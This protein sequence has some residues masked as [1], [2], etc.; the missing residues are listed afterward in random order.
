MSEG[1]PQLLM[2]TGPDFLVRDIREILDR[3][4]ASLPQ[5]VDAAWVSAT[6]KIPFKVLV[7]RETLIWRVLELGRSALQGFETNKI[8]SAII[9]TRA[10]LETSAALW[11]LGAKLDGVI[12]AETLGDI[13]DKVMRL[14]FGSRVYPELGDAI[15]V[16]TFID[17]MDKE[18][19]GL[20]RSYD[21][22]SEY[23]HPNWA[24]AGLL[25]S[26]EDPHNL[27]TEFGTNIRCDESSKEVGV[28]S[29][30]GALLAFEVCYNRLADIL[31]V[32]IELCEKGLKAAQTNN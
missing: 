21:R 10:A 13:D 11:Y 15:N 29:L 31:R 3:I 24:G 27:S 8:A 5:R 23:A 9:L 25:Y 6:A 7:Y 2:K 12:Q 28:A 16:L 14:M 20:R 30:M 32:F 22:L 1:E 4:E 17:K 18:V 19:P 26:R